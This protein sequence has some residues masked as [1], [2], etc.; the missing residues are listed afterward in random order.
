MKMLLPYSGFYSNLFTK[1]LSPWYTSST[2]ARKRQDYVAEHTPY[3]ISVFAFNDRLSRPTL[4]DVKCNLQSWF[5][6]LQSIYQLKNKR[7]VH[8]RLQKYWTFQSPCPKGLFLSLADHVKTTG[9][10]WNGIVLTYFSVGKTEIYCYI[11]DCW[12]MRWSR[13]AGNFDTV[14]WLIRMR[15][16][17][18]FIT[19][20]YSEVIHF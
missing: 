3:Q 2:L 15:W 20:A 11:V 6:G 4:S 1:C 9:Q 19:A 5:P 7:K 16:C 18:M 14:L 13:N 17:T 12:F 10:T 8:E